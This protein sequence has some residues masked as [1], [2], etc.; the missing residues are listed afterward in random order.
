[1]GAISEA[2]QRDDEWMSR[3]KERERQIEAFTPTDDQL[4]EI[5]RRLRGDERALADELAWFKR[6]YR[7]S[8][9]G[10]LD[11]ESALTQFIRGVAPAS[12]RA[13]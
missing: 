11:P 2:K 7:D 3:R 4:R 5:R 12:F 1:M 10:G 6:R 9:F 8:G 13:A